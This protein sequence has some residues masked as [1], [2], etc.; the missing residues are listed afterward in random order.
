MHKA[1]SSVTFGFKTPC[2]NRIEW[3]LCSAR[4]TTAH[5][6]T[7]S[8][9][10]LGPSGH[11]HY[12]G[13][14]SRLGIRVRSPLALDIF[15]SG[16]VQHLVRQGERKAGSMVQCRTL[17]PGSCN[18]RYFRCS[19]ELL[20][21]IKVLPWFLAIFYARFYLTG[22][23]PAYELESRMPSAQTH[24]AAAATTAGH[25]RVRCQF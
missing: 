13:Q 1:C 22:P 20:V 8:F 11:Q 2:L 16:R 10:P 12:L 15:P 5:S 7:A 4:P 21:R 9:S 17:G 6:V 25:V 14:A 23:G 18:A 19:P 3:L 24:A